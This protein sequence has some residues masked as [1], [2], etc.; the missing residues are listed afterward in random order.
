MN[1]QWPLM[2][3]KRLLAPFTNK[4]K[5]VSSE[6]SGSETRTEDQDRE[7]NLGQMGTGSATGANGTCSTV[8]GHLKVDDKSPVTTVRAKNGLYC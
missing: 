8:C 3:P 5:E 4:R 7:R 6:S 2:T 1:K